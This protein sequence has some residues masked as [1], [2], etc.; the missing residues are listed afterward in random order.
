MGIEMGQVV[1]AVVS[2]LPPG[3]PYVVGG[4]VLALAAV[5]W[6]GNPSAESKET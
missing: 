5:F 3:V 1:Q 4:T 6:A 2:F